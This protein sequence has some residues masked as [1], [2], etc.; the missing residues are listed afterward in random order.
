[1]PHA[2]TTS[3][4]P[5]LCTGCGSCISVCLEET[6]VLEDDKAVVKGGNSLGCD[7]CGAICPAEAIKVGFVDEDALTLKTVENPAKLVRLG[8]YDTTGLVALMRSRRSCRNFKETPVQLQVLEDLVKIGT[9]AP[10]G[11]NNQLWTFTIVPNR[12]AVM[13]IGE[14]AIVFFTKLNKLSEKRLVRGFSKL[15]LKDQIGLYYR[16]YHQQVTDAIKE[17]HR[18]KKDLLFHGAPALILVGSEPGASCPKED[19]L[20]ASQ[21]ILLAAHSM[22]YGTCLIGFAVEAITHHPA[23]KTLIGIPKEEKIHAVIA[24]GESKEKYLRFAGRRKIV[25]RRFEG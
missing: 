6:I 3:I 4:D 1:M 24:L 12:E 18:T 15:F 11:T 21:N 20:L 14:E 19:A 16:E 17:W 2:V 23:I 25:P 13:K 10:S 8:E 5:E 22:G 9:T 7:H